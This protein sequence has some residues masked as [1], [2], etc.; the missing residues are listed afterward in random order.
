MKLLCLISSGIDSPVAAYLMLKKGHEVEF[1]HMK[2]KNSHKD[3]EK[4]INFL[5]KTLG[6]NL[7]LHV[8]EHENFLKNAKKKLSPSETK[9]T[10]ILCK[11]QMIKSASEIAEKIHAE[12]LLTGDNLAQVASQTMQNLKAESH[13]SKIQILR[14]LIALNKEE[15]IEISR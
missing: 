14:P 8:V 2:I 5:S 11:R 4:V 12:F 6:K 9:N 13:A 7:K 10:C 3:V 1:V 15:I